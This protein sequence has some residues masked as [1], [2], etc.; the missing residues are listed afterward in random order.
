[1][2]VVV[3]RA[4]V[5]DAATVAEMALKLFAQHRDY[6]PERFADLSHLKGAERFYGSRMSAADAAVLVAETDGKV[7]GFAY[8]QYEELDYVQLL[9]NAAWLHD[10]YVDEAARGTG[11]GKALIAAAK[12]AGIAFGADKL[13]LTVAARNEHAREFF[14]RTGLRE[15]MV[16]MTIGLND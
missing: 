14:T 2:S 15:T 5:E 8:M 9:E 3:R 11:A 12:D 7:V 13:V 16:E 10:L 4:Q 6:D 1:M